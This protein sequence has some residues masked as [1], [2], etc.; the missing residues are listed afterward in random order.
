M[1]ISKANLALVHAVDQML[2]YYEINKKDMPE[3]VSVTKLTYDAL[4]AYVGMDKGIEVKELTHYRNVPIAVV[5]RNHK[6]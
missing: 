1:T 4:V 3:K 2:D 6:T 5:S